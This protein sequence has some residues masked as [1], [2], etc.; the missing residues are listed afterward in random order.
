[1]T[2]LLEIYSKW[3]N[4]LTFREAFR[5]NPEVALKEAGIQVSEEDLAKIKAK[6]ALDP[7]EN[8]TLDDRIS[9]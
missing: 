2:Q 9:K 4:N 6:F 8:D 7:S 5:L 3:A 1:M